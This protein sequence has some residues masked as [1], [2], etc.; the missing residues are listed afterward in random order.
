MVQ[1]GE[2]G[3]VRH[4]QCAL[5]TNL[6][7]LFDDPA[8]VGWV[9]ATGNMAGNGFGWGQSSHQFAWIYFVTGLSPSSVSCHMTHSKRSGADVFVSATVR[10]TSGATISMQG[11]ASTLPGGSNTVDNKVF[12]TDGF[13]SYCGQ[14]DPNG[15]PASGGLELH[16][17]DGRS[18]NFPGFCYENLEPT[19]SGP[20]SLQAFIGGCLG[21]PFFNAVDATV[22]LRAVLT[23]DAMYRSAKSGREEVVIAP[24]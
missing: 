13:I 19:G 2:I 5:L 21:R 9:K 1:S 3:E 14:G 20:E 22:G 7:W 15:D 8:N 11:L 17:H 23:I 24:P 4:V 6:R 10:C 18:L 16:R 12:G